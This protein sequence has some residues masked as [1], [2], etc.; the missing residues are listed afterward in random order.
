MY[1]LDEGRVTQRGL[2]PVVAIGRLADMLQPGN[3]GVHRG[4]HLGFQLPFHLVERPLLVFEILHPLEITDHDTAAVRDDV[5]Q[6]HDAPLLEQVV[7]TRRDRRIGRLH[8]QFRPH[9][10]CIVFTDLAFQR[11]RDEYVAVAGDQVFVGDRLR[12]GQADDAAVLGLVRQ[13]RHRIEAVIV[14]NAAP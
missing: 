10:G 3:D 1:G 5:R 9:G 4:F 2:Q 12:L 13:N 14:G 8:D 7:G 11:S 6:D